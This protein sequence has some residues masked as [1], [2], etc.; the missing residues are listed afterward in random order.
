MIDVF[1]STS[2]Y[3]EIDFT[4]KVSTVLGVHLFMKLYLAYLLID[5]IVFLR[6]LCKL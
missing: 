5:F 1:S 4:R 3:H 6:D 2:L